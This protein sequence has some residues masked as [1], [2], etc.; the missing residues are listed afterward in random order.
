MK[1]YHLIFLSFTFLIGGCT[2]SPQPQVEDYSGQSTS[3]VSV[4]TGKQIDKFYDDPLY[5]YH[6]EFDWLYLN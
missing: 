1:K 6:N 3:A 5:Y 4:Q 2:V